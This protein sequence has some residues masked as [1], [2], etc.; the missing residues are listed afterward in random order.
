MR[1]RDVEDGGVYLAKVSDRIVP[2]RIDRESRHGGWDA[3]N[4]Q[5]GRRIHVRSAQRLRGKAAPIVTDR[6]EP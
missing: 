4:L 5:T 2:V 1:K 6:R 3:T